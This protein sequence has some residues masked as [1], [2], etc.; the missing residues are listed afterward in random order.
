LKNNRLAAPFNQRALPSSA[1]AWEK[2]LMAGLKLD[3]VHEP[4]F[5]SVEEEAFLNRCAPRTASTA[6][7]T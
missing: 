4:S 7:F 3:I 2:V 1:T 6:P 5:P